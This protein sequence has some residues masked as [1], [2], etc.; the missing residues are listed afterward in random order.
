[1]VSHLLTQAGFFLALSRPGFFLSTILGSR[2]RHPAMRVI[3]TCFFASTCMIDLPRRSKGFRAGSC[4]NKALETASA[5]ASAC[6]VMPPPL[7]RAKMLYLSILSEILRD[8]IAL[9]RSCI[10]GKM[11]TM[12]LPL[13]RISPVPS[14]KC[15]R[16][17]DSFRRPTPFDLPNSSSSRGFAA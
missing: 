7:T 17:D 4:T 3:S 9:S 10:R 2:V 11:S 6:P 5:I 1:M 12:L 13:T 16:A 15:T 14:I 8:H